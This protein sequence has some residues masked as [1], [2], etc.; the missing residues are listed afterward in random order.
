LY[1]V[2]IGSNIKGYNFVKTEI[3]KKIPLVKYFLFKNR[4]IE[5]MKKKATNESFI[6]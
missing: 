2:K 4:V 1:S 6:P 3:E 5:I